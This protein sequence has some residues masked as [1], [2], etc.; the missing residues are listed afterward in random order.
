M[1]RPSSQRLLDE[2]KT[3]EY[4]QER[5]RINLDFHWSLLSLFKLFSHLI[6][7][8]FNLNQSLELVG[9]VFCLGDV[10]TNWQNFA[11][12][13]IACWS[14]WMHLNLFLFL[15]FPI[16][17]FSHLTCSSFN[18]SQSLELVGWVFCL[19]DV[20]TNWQSF[21]LLVI[22]SRMNLKLWGRIKKRKR[23]KRWT[24]TLGQPLSK[25]TW[26]GPTKSAASSVAF[27]FIWLCT[28]AEISKYCPKNIAVTREW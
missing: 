14:S 16:S 5:K 20:H 27:N 24:N 25:W 17:P 4:N 18:F 12:I 23:K 9:W 19:G 3:L 13:I 1:F 7:S 21:A 10:H 2:P 26:K 22:D 15:G 28:V 8:S 6:C 11:L